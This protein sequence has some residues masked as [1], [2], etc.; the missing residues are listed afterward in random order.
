MS[1]MRT[2]RI[3]VEFRKPFTLPGF[4]GPQPAGTYSIAIDEEPV[5]ELSFLAYRRTAAWIDIVDPRAPLGSSEC[6][7]VDPQALDA[8]LQRDA[9]D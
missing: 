4:D 1:E 8:A 2:T 5:E 7:R 9:A 3:K 6:V